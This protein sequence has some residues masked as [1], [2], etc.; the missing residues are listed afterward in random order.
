MDRYD[1][2]YPAISEEEQEKLK[3]SRIFVAGCG[4]LGGYILEFLIRIGVGNIIAC[5]GDSFC[6]SNLNRQLL[7]KYHFWVFQRLGLQK[8]AVLR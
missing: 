6:E 4:G 5:D 1:R 2:N 3:N 8:C 7:S